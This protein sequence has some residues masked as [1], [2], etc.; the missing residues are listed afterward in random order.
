MIVTTCV[1][2]APV[3]AVFVEGNFG[4]N[5]TIDCVTVVMK[6][7]E[8]ISVLGRLASGGAVKEWE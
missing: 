6:G 1:E 4:W 7:G 2:V 8:L 3:A 5:H